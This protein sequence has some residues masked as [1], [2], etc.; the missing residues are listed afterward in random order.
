MD[1]KVKFYDVFSSIKWVEKAQ[2]IPKPLVTIAFATFTQL[3]HFVSTDA[4]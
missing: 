3:S 4:S 1:F 2:K